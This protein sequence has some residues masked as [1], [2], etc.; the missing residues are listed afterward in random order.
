MDKDVLK[1]LILNAFQKDPERPLGRNELYM[2]IGVEVGD[3]ELSDVLG[4][5]IRE[6][7]I[8]YY[9]HRQIDFYMLKKI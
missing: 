4:E 8:T 5:L 6:K 9:Y 2:K 7:L 1:L 3:Y